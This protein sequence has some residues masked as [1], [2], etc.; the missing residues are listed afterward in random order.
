[1]NA[2]TATGRRV[3]AVSLFFVLLASAGDCGSG[4]GD[5]TQGRTD[6]E[7]RSQTGTEAGSRA[8]AAPVSEAGTPAAAQAETPTDVQPRAGQAGGVSEL[9]DEQQRELERIGTL[10]YTVGGDRAPEASGVTGS[11]PTAF[12]GYTVYVSADFPGA[13]LLDMEGRVVHTWQEEHSE[14]WVRAWVYPDG[15]ILG[16]S[17]YPGRLIKLGRDSEFLWTYGDRQLRAH[18]DVTVGPDGTIVVLMRIG[19]VLE[20]L[21]PEG[22]LEDLICILEPGE[23][24]PAEVA[25]ISIPEAFRDSEY[26]HLLEPSALGSDGDPFH[27]NCIEILDGTVPHPAFREGNFLVTIRNM[28][29][30][31]VIDPG[32]RKVIWANTGRWQR[33]HEA[34]V[35]PNGHLMLFDNRKFDGWSRV[36]EYDVV[37]DEI[38]WS[39]EEDGFFSRGTG[40]QQL[41]PN[42]NV[43]ITESQKGRV[44]EV[45]RD[46]EVVWEFWNP[47]RLE[48]GEA[49]VRVTRASRLPYDYFDPG[50]TEPT[51]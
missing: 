23:E 31:A 26:A 22:L 30:L 24:V 19:R 25:S 50:F 21:R 38:V 51:Q 42:G 49:I 17:A 4:G 41:L 12:E 1:M 44:F 39:Y 46:G 47:S 8:D 14:H 13:Y 48:E 36:V 10:G 16:V 34:R 7:A 15:S 40:A 20:W 45:T 43:L 32:D 29:C 35:L 27:T 11:D 9:T 18:H 37:A 2:P 28:D 3:L 5:E 6:A 33:M